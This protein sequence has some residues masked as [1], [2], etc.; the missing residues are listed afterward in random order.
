MIVFVILKLKK[1]HGFLFAFWSINRLDT[2]DYQREHDI[3][4]W[5]DSLEIDTKTE[6]IFFTQ[7]ERE[8]DKFK[9]SRSGFVTGIYRQAYTEE[10]DTG[11]IVPVEKWQMWKLERILEF[12]RKHPIKAYV[13]A[14][15]QCS[16]IW[17]ERNG[18]SCLKEYIHD[19]LY[20]HTH[21]FIGNVEYTRLRH[22]CFK[23]VHKLSQYNYILIQREDNWSPRLRIVIRRK[24]EYDYDKCVRQEELIE[25]FEDKYFNKI[26]I[27]QYDFA[28]DELFKTEKKEDAKLDKSFRK[29]LRYYVERND[30]DAKLD[31]ESLLSC[32]CRYLLLDEISGHLKRGV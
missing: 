10:N 23:F 29:I 4:Q 7:Y 25:K 31:E 5:C 27:D 21:K 30:A 2:L 15:H 9:P 18:L 3:I 11:K 1:Y 26:S 24:E 14:Y 20:Y 32:N 13:Y 17:E 12:M 16:D 19:W 6:L 28:L 8:L 22:K